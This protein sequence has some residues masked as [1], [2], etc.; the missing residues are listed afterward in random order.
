MLTINLTNDINNVVKIIVKERIMIKNWF[1]NKVQNVKNKFNEVKDNLTDP[2]T[3]WDLL[4]YLK[5]WILG[6]IGLVFGII[7][8]YFAIQDF[9]CDMKAKAIN[10]TGEYSWWMG[11]CVFAKGEDK[12]LLR[13]IKRISVDD[14]APEDVF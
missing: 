3:W 7:W 1:K 4:D 9:R 2:D 11:E 8:L 13:Q 5:W 12:F 10:H 14:E 6:F